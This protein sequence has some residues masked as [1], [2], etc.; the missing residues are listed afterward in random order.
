MSEYDK[1]AFII[2]LATGLMTKGTLMGG[3][4]AG[5]ESGCS[6]CMFEWD[7][8]TRTLSV[9]PLG[10]GEYPYSYLGST[11]ALEAYVEDV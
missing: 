10:Y 3:E 5:D 11:Q 7:D 9:R 4:P 1:H 8:V 2:G 6:L